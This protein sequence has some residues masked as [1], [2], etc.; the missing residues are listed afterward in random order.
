M[1]GGDFVIPER[2]GEYRMLQSNCLMKN[3]RDE[4]TYT[5]NHINFHNKLFVRV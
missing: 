2:K 1:T 4:N 3:I 5:L